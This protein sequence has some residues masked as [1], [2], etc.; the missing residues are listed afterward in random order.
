MQVAILSSGCLHDRLRRMPINKRF[1]IQA[2]KHWHVH[3]FPVVPLA[4]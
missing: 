2:Q 1:G 3:S 4:R